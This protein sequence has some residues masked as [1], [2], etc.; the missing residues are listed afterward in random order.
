MAHSG[1]DEG[2]RML[3]VTVEGLEGDEKN[4]Y[5]LGNITAERYEDFKKVYFVSHRN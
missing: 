1:N 2:K 5:Q 3:K 4:Y